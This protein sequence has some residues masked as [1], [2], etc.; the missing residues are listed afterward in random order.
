MQI[1]LRVLFNFP[2]PP[3]WISFIGII[4]FILI[5]SKYDLS[6]ILFIGTTVF[7]LLSQVNV[8]SIFQTTVFDFSVILLAVIMFFIPL[9]GGLMQQ[10]NLMMETIERMKISNKIALMLTP[11][12]FG[13]LPVAGGALM[14][15]PLVDQIDPSLKAEQKIAINVWFRH[16]LV[17]I[18]PLSQVIL[19]CTEIAGLNQYRTVLF[20][21]PPFLV[22]GAAGYWFLIRPV[23]EKVNNH[24]RDFKK[25][26][27]NLIPLLLAPLLDLISRL[28][29]NWKYPEI[30]TIIGLILS[31]L[32]IYSYTKFELSLLPTIMGKMKI[33][34]FPLLIGAIFYFL[35]VF[36]ASGVPMQIGSFQMSFF[37]L[38]VLGFFL[39]IATGRNQ[40]P[41]S[42]LIPIYLVQFQVNIMPMA[43]FVSLYVA[44]FT[45]YLL[46]P[47]HPCLAYSIKYFDS[48]Y[49]KSLKMLLPPAIFSLISVFVFYTSYSLFR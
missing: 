9:L 46:T 38:M 41:F 2:Y 47:L 30:V 25:V 7:G 21:I 43:E 29:F 37:L 13:L 5:F 32:L 12:L 35:N 20:L 8:W 44:I 22:M 16:L 36:N 42:L 11:A 3:A 14:S 10:T 19:I 26:A 40:M 31:I 1:E 6:L 45:G 33:W 39:G 15:A 27:R 17:F 18:Y 28:V 48:N 24:T 4:V 49:W 34:R 23:Q